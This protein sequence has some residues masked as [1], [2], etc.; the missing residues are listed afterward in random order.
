MKG[1]TDQPVLTHSWPQR[2]L[3]GQVEKRKKPRG[4]GSGECL[5]CPQ[6][7]P[8]KSAPAASST[9]TN[10]NWSCTRPWF[11]IQRSFNLLGTMCRQKRTLQEIRLPM[12]YVNRLVQGRIEVWKECSLTESTTVRCFWAGSSQGRCNQIHKQIIISTRTWDLPYNDPTHHITC[13]YNNHTWQR[14]NHS[15]KQIQLVS[16]WHCAWER[17]LIKH[18]GGQ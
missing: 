8:S 11:P 2:S 17:A 14:T 9:V 7:G 5:R 6:R 3:P 10:E 13:V 16:L 15:N 4:W 18:A 12:C 1:N